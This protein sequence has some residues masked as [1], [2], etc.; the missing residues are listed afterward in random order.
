MLLALSTSEDSPPLEPDVARMLGDG[1]Q[2]LI[3]RIVR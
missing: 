2:A 3:E 1:W